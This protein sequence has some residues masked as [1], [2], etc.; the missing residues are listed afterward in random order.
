M[1]QGNEKRGISRAEY[2]IDCQLV[3]KN[4]TLEGKL[5]NFS[6]TGLLITCEN[7]SI[8]KEGD[9]IDIVLKQF[10]ETEFISEISCDVVRVDKTSLGL[11]FSAIDYD[12]LVKLK[13]LLYQLVNDNDKI[14][15]EIFNY[16]AKK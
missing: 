10:I 5:V 6:L 2:Q 14:D 13:D 7:S 8:F 4:G 1:T 12:T 9:S 16:I 3:H 11:K 15:D